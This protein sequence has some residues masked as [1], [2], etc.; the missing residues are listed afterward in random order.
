MSTAPSVPVLRRLV[1]AV[2]AVVGALTVLVLAAA[3]AGAHPGH[4]E[5]AGHAHA[6][7]PGPSVLLVLAVVVAVGGVLLVAR[8]RVRRAAPIRR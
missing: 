1:A 7:V 2:V 5:E 3:P 8:P 6:A 4:G